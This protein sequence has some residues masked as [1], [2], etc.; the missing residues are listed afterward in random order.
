MNIVPIYRIDTLKILILISISMNKAES[1]VN[2][3][4]D[5]FI[6]YYFTSNINYIEVGP[7]KYIPVGQS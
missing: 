5:V 6:F 3:I 7:Q 4:D 2:N 1:I